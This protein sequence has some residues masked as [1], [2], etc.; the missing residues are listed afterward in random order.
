M[1]KLCENISC[2]YP[3]FAKK[4][5]KNHQHL[6]TDKK[7]KS[8][9]RTPIRKVSKKQNTSTVRR[10]RISQ[11][12]KDWE[13]YISIWDERLHICENCSCSLGSEPLTIFFDH[14]LEKSKHPALRYEKNNIWLLCWECHTNKTNGLYSL[15]MLDKLVKTSTNF[16]ITIHF[17]DY[18]RA[19]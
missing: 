17:I 18:K 4:F 7:V 11:R 10:E 12:N 6:R 9:K 14:I 8:L 15:L 13:F 19:A 2:G 3:V 1:P 16:G 5:C